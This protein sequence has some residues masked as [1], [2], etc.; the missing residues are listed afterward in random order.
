MATTLTPDELNN[1][2]SGHETRALR[3]GVRFTMQLNG[4]S[5]DGYIP[6]KQKDREADNQ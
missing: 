4:H 5:L 2:S 3:I 6:Q 1:L